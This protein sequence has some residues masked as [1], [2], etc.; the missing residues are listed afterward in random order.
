MVE[1]QRKIQAFILAGG[2]SSRMGYDKGLIQLSDGYLVE[3]VIR[4]LKQLD[5]N[6]VIVSAN[7]QYDVFGLTRIEDEYV[8]KG[9]MGG[10]YA[11]LHYSFTDYNLFLSCDMPFL[12][13]P[14]LHCLLDSL[15]GHQ[16]AVVPIHNKQYEPLCAVYHKSLL[17]N[18]RSRLI[19]QQLGLIS[20]LKEVNAVELNVSKMPFYHQHLFMN[21][22]T[23]EDLLAL[24]EIIGA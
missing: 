13:L 20:W 10:I 6:P 2:K 11:G 7:P 12:S 23:P 8:E 24:K 1:A 19:A 5:L 21:V 18:L 16:Q 4:V 15:E 3:R 9:P 22:N 14:L 17:P